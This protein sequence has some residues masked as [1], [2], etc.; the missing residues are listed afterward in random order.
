V[1]INPPT[2]EQTELDLETARGQLTAGHSI[3]Q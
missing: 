2:L 3:P 1:A